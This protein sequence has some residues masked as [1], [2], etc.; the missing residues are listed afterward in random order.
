VK[1]PHVGQVGYQEVAT[2]SYKFGGV[3]ILS[4]TLPSRGRL[5]TPEVDAFTGEFVTISQFAA[6]VVYLIDS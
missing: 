3:L 5:A 2:S 1:P 4:P 6:I